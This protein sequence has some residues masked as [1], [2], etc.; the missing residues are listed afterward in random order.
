MEMKISD[1][2]N[3]TAIFVSPI[4]AV[5]ISIFIQ[6]RRER[7]NRKF[8]TFLTL[9]STRHSVASEEQV[10]AFN[11]IDVLYHKCPDVRRHWREYLELLNQPGRQVEW[12]VKKLALLK[13]MAKDLGYRDSI[14]ALDLFRAYGPKGLIEEREKYGKIADELL[15][16]LKATAKITTSLEPVPI[17]SEAG[18]T[19]VVSTQPFG[20]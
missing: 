18:A 9:I 6:E 14:D 20:E 11:S 7:K 3:V 10:R 8:T 13:S 5:W 16:V 17:S 12:E 15:R 2:L 19:P 1:W 4:L